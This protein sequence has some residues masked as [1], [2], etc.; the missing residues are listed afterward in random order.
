MVKYRKRILLCCPFNNEDHSMKL[1]MESL[2]KIDY[3]RSLIDL[4]LL[5]NNSTDDTW[6]L[7]KRHHK[8]LKKLNWHS[9]SLH[10]VTGGKLFPKIRADQFAKPIFVRKKDGKG[11]LMAPVYSGKH[12]VWGKHVHERAKNVRDMYFFFFDL[13]KP[14]HDFL[15]MMM[16]DM[17]YPPNILKRY[18]GVFKRFPD[19]GWVGGCH[20]R[21]FP[22]NRIIAAPYI[23]GNFPI[24]RT[25]EYL[26]V[27]RS[28]REPTIHDIMELRRKYGLVFEVFM[29]GHG[30]ML[31]SRVIRECGWDIDTKSSIEIVTPIVLSMWK[32]GLKVYCASD[33]Y[34]VHISLDG[35]VY[36]DELFSM[37]DK[38]KL[39]HYW[40]SV[41]NEG[42]AHKERLGKL[43]IKGETMPDHYAK[44]FYSKEAQQRLAEKVAR[45][46]K[47]EE[48]KIY[49]KFV[50][51]H[52]R[53]NRKIPNRPNTGSVFDKISAQN[54]TAETWDNRY[55]KW[56]EFIENPQKFKNIGDD[57][58]SI[59]KVEVNGK[60]T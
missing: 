56:R 33:I 11:G 28:V 43:K 2:F 51:L 52:L 32:M 20:R 23:F 48:F 24:K 8:R 27:Y 47:E 5:E 17:V 14:E 1:F 3:P 19:A 53:C 44:V 37:E 50:A 26:K 60:H 12:L 35:K 22:T 10:R 59:V 30:F 42:L 25:P 41:L 16:T 49:S 7:L 58:D 54:L 13:L 55:G 29:T 9:I 38:K 18:V 40:E 21:R 4:V 31:P 45:Y 15:M 57:D 6:K 46:D 36:E 39:L 34:Q